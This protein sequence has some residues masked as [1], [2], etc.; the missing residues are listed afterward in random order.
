MARKLANPPKPP[1]EPENEDDYL[2]IANIEE[3]SKLELDLN[4]L[5]EVRGIDPTSKL[6]ERLIFS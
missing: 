5:H 6:P 1:R 3:I 2:V 4:D